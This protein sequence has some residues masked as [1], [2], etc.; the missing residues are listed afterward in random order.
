MPYNQETGERDPGDIGSS[1]V[2]PNNLSTFP[3][4]M[5]FSFYEYQ[6]PDLVNQQISG[7]KFLHNKGTIRLPLPNSMIDSQHVEYSKESLGLA[8]AAAVNAA[9]GNFQNAGFEAGAAIASTKASTGLG[10]IGAGQSALAGILATQGVALNPFLTVLFKSPAFKQHTL[11]WILAPSNENESRILNKIV[12]EFRKNMLPNQSG[13]LGGSLLTYPKIVQTTVSC[14]T[15]DFFTYRFRPA[16][17]ENFNI[18]FTPQ[19]QPSFFGSTKAPTSVEIRLELME[20]EYWL[21]NDY[22]QDPYGFSAELT[23]DALKKF[24]TNTASGYERSY[25]HATPGT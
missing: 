21:S 15:E 10:A 12:T 17:I 7:E 25:E 24:F 20:I 3:F 4:W 14:N 1:M 18:N 11:S 23:N 13:A 5:S 22:G 19:A 8:G 9:R 16:V 2:F 6:M